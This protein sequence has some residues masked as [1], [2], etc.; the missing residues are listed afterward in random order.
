MS[1][2]RVDN[3]E[4]KEENASHQLF[5]IGQQ[6]SKVFALVM[7]STQP[8]LNLHDH[9]TQMNLRSSTRKVKA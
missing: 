9:H 4:R 8:D 3:I 5:I 1:F 6:S 2:E 7:I